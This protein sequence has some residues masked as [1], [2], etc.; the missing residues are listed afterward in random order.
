MT[1]LEKVGTLVSRNSKEGGGSYMIVGHIDC[2][3]CNTE[4]ELREVIELSKKQRKASANKKEY[5]WCHKCGLYSA[6]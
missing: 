6:K 1:T 4:I 3:R 2:E 5:S